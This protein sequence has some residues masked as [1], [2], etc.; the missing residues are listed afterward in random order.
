MIEYTDCCDDLTPKQVDGFFIGWPNPPS[1]GT[2]LKIL[3]GSTHIVVAI[4]DES[5]HVVGFIN[6]VA[7]GVLAAYIPLL[8]VLPDF[9]HKQ[10][11]TQLVRRMIDKL[12]DY[13][14]IDLICDDKLRP[15][16]QRFGLGPA[17]G[18]VIRNF[19]RQSGA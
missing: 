11:G 8:E 19:K 14:M 17:G 10:I 9:Q 18:M 6:A 1:P 15:F 4:D 7:D 2:L 13:Y 12:K 16:Y 5:G 3:K